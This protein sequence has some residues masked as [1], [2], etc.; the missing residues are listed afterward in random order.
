VASRSAWISGPLCQVSEHALGPGEAADQE[1]RPPG[2]EFPGDISRLIVAASADGIVAVDENGV[3]RLCNRAAEQLF[4]RPA[5]ELIGTPFGFPLV[6][7]RATEVSLMLP[8]GGERVVEMRA[9]TMTLEGEL[10]HVA[11]LRDVTRRRQAERELE[12][13]LER[14]N[15]VV[16]VAA[17]E[18]HNPLAAISMLTHVLQDEQAALT[19]TQRRDIIERIAERTARLQLLVR[20]LLTASRIDAVGVQAASERVPVLEIIVEQLA[21]A[22]ERSAEVSVSCTPGLESVVDRAELSTILA[23]CLENAFA[24]ARPPIE[25]RAAERNG[26]VEIRVIDQGPG[27]PESF[28]PHLFDRFTREPGAEQ[29]AE[30]TGLG[31]WIVRNFAQANGGDAWYEPGKHGG[32]CFCVRLPLPERGSHRPARG[33]AMPI[34]R[35]RCGYTPT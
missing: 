8:G 11:A 27:V 6:A 24:Y 15:I 7:G 9:T 2:A 19:A 5:K 21:D 10:F 23:N 20:K 12:A 28:V 22:D 4:A 13:A 35:S 30:G 17:H 31:L 18:L 34:A 1:Q 16:A 3:I 25:V 32:S 33:L 26:W 29:K 14:Q